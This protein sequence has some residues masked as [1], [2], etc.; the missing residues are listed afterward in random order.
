MFGRVGERGGEVVNLSMSHNIA[1]FHLDTNRLSLH[2]TKVSFYQL[3]LNILYCS[4]KTPES[5]SIESTHFLGIVVT[6]ALSSWWEVHLRVDFNYEETGYKLLGWENGNWA[7]KKFERLEKTFSTVSQS[8]SISILVKA[9]ASDFSSDSHSTVKRSS[10]MAYL[11]LGG[12]SVLLILSGVFTIKN[13][14]SQINKKKTR[15]VIEE[16]SVV[17][18]QSSEPEDD[19]I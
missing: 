11:M 1:P 2:I 15:C 14:S 10:L 6:N 7:H 4:I 19:Q 9:E 13:F 8:K 17:E 12:I 18:L 16:E 3:D 5:L